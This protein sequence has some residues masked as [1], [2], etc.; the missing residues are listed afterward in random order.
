MVTEEQSLAAR[1]RISTQEAQRLLQQQRRPQPTTAQRFTPDQVAAQEQAVQQ[2]QQSIEDWKAALDKFDK[3]RRGKGFATFGDPT[4]I[5]SKVNVLNESFRAG[6]IGREG[7]AQ[8]LQR[9]GLP[10]EIVN[11]AAEFIRQ[12]REFAAPQVSRP[13]GQL[14]VPAVPG[15]VGEGVR[16]GILVRDPTTGEVTEQFTTRARTPQRTEAVGPTISIPTVMTTVTPL[17]TR[18][19]VKGLFFDFRSDPR[20]FI[21]ERF[22]RQIQRNLGNIRKGLE[23]TTQDIR[24]FVDPETVR[25]EERL[26]M[27]IDQQIKDIRNFNREASKSSLSVDQ[28]ENLTRE[29]DTLLEKQDQIEIIAAETERLSGFAGRPERL[30][31]LGATSLLTAPTRLLGLGIGL[32]AFPM[33]TSREVTVGLAG[34]PSQFVK[35]PFGTHAQLL[36]DALFFEALS[37]LRAKPVSKVPSKKNLKVS[38]SISVDDAIKISDDAYTVSSKIKTEVRNAKTGKLIDSSTTEAPSVVMVAKTKEGALKTFSEQ[39]SITIK[40]SNVRTF[41]KQGKIT[42]KGDVRKGQ[43]KGTFRLDEEGLLKGEVETAIEDVGT[44]RFIFGLG[45]ESTS[46]LT[47][48][49]TPLKDTGLSN[50]ISKVLSQERTTRN[51]QG[52]IFEG[53]ETTAASRAITSVSSENVLVKGFK[54]VTVREGAPFTASIVKIPKLTRKRGIEPRI[55]PS[56]SGGISTVFEPT[57][58][59]S[60]STLFGSGR[61]VKGKKTTKPRGDA[62]VSDIL[63][64]PNTAEVKAV[65][66]EGVAAQAAARAEVNTIASS[67]GREVLQ[68]SKARVKTT[69]IIKQSPSTITLLAA[70]SNSASAL[71]P[72]SGASYLTPQSTKPSIKEIQGIASA[73]ETQPS[74]RQTEQPIGLIGLPTVPPRLRDA[75]LKPSPKTPKVLIDSD[76]EEEGKKKVRAYKTMVRRKGKFRQVGGLSSLRT[77]LGRGAKKTDNTPAATFKVVAT[78]KKINKPK[79]KSKTYQQIGFKFR[80]FKASPRGK[81]KGKLPTLTFIEKRKFRFDTAGEQKGITA[82]AAPAKKRKS[83]LRRMFGI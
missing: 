38:Q 25:R 26:K 42:V 32:V 1:L 83:A 37:I 7:T 33:E 68:R 63:G 20:G 67:V 65:T 71:S 15:A 75:P 13:S 19:Q 59:Q 77:A 2:R 57:L 52:L 34:L 56:R 6:R 39:A 36:G 35:D 82:K 61:K 45:R 53:T 9:L 29:R 51:I 31:I 40:E 55:E 3:I 81:P 27:L 66:T 80:Q 5:T 22:P 62:T 43:S 14:P 18:Q 46:R 79:K 60:I 64:T 47:R 44:A 28:V 74:L 78:N 76:E 41:A 54:R 30:A 11:Q 4:E 50:T 69:T 73:Q 70:A 12:E 23:E 8:E 48:T 72:I 21:V 58:D 49:R 10:P 17:T 16:G 24:K